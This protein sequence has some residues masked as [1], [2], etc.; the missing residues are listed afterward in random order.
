MLTKSANATLITVT[1]IVA[2]A[3]LAYALSDTSVRALGSSGVPL[4]MLWVQIAI[5]ICAAVFAAIA[6]NGRGIRESLAPSIILLVV[7]LLSMMSAALYTKSLVDF[8]ADS[9]YSPSNPSAAQVHG[10]SG[11]VMSPGVLR[12][13]GLATILVAILTGYIRR[14]QPAPMTLIKR[15]LLSIVVTVALSTLWVT[16]EGMTSRVDWW[17]FGTIH[18]FCWMVITC[19][20]LPLMVVIF[21]LALATVNI[22]SMRAVVVFFATGLGTALL[23]V[24]AVARLLTGSGLRAPHSMNTTVALLGVCRF[25]ANA[26]AVRAALAAVTVIAAAVLVRVNTRRSPSHV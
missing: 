23:T 22:P 2:S 17:Y 11:S 21:G 16:S 6:F 14:S 3:T 8:G 12:G 9:D 26:I 24:T 25:L 15:T 20:V 13:F 10:M 4:V 5:P 19:L 1:G 7:L 18:A